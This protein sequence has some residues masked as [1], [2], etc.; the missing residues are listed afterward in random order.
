MLD[1]QFLQNGLRDV[2]R[3]SPSTFLFF[4]LNT[5]HTFLV[6]GVQ[7]PRGL[8]DDSA[9]GNL[10]QQRLLIFKVC[11]VTID[12]NKVFRPEA[13]PR[14]PYE[15]SDALESHPLAADQ[16]NQIRN[17]KHPWVTSTAHWL[18]RATA[19]LSTQP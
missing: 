9:S 15:T 10:K 11:R 3:R 16:S 8:E 7:D 14:V 12:D 4:K 2:E 1:I 5:D 6:K 19:T 17:H 18:N 13:H